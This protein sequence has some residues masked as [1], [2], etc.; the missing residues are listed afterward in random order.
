[1][2]IKKISGD[3]IIVRL[4]DSD[5]EHFQIDTNKKIPQSANLHKLLFEVMELVRIETGFDPY[6]GG[7]VVVE[8]EEVDNGISLVISKIKGQSRKLTREEFSRIRSV[9]I[10][11]DKDDISRMLKNAGQ[12]QKEGNSHKTT[13][14]F[15]SFDDFESAM[16]AVDSRVFC[17]SGLYR[18]ENG[19][20]LIMDN[21]S[22]AIA[23]NILS[24]Y[25]SLISGNCV[26]AYGIQEGWR[27]L[28]CGSSLIRMSEEIRQMNS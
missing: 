6:S 4:T 15:D 8:A 2:I 10:K 16:C 7:Q 1:M 12:V 19:Y 3:K 27:E 23:M 25:S 5:L 9:H 22:D 21:T 11:K 17:N 24:E 14:I 28:A 26:V 13:Y 18:S 20:A